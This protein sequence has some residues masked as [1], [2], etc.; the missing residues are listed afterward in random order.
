MLSIFTTTVRSNIE[1]E[2]D[3]DK[4]KQLREQWVA[5]LEPLKNEIKKREEILRRDFQAE[6]VKGLNSEQESTWVTLE[7]SEIKSNGKTEF[8]KL[9]DGSYLAS[10]DKTRYTINIA[11]RPKQIPGRSP[12]CVW[13]RW[14]MRVCPTMVRGEQE[15]GISV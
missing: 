1:V 7:I 12:G 4:T 6:L 5:T 8:N 11:S 10:G 3:P 14:P 9:S 13:K 2:L 15:M